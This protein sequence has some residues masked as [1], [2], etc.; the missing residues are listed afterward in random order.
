MGVEDGRWC[1]VVCAVCF[2]GAGGC[3]GLENLKFHAKSGE[4]QK[5]TCIALVVTGGGGWREWLAMTGQ[6]RG[7]FMFRHVPCVSDSFRIQ[8][9]KIKNAFV[10]KQCKNRRSSR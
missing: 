8:V 2:V 7:D 5:Q 4:R 9:K 10:Q 3:E 1:V 6:S